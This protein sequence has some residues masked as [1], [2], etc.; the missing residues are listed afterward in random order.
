MNKL[1][2]RELQ[3]CKYLVE[4]KNN[5]EIARLMFLSKHTVKSYVSMIIAD[6]GA[7]NRTHVAYLLGKENIINM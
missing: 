1:T 2:Q 5:T 7:V 4:G 3:I 6:M